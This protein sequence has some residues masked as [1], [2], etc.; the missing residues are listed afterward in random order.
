MTV[1]EVARF[2]GF[3]PRHIRRA[4]QYGWIDAHK[5]HGRWVITASLEEIAS[6]LTLTESQ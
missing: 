5:K 4:C 6:I 3:D 2:T 1:G